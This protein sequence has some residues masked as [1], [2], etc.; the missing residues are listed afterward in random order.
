MSSSSEYGCSS[1]PGDLRPHLLRYV[2]Q[3]R[4]VEELLAASERDREG[5]VEQYSKAEEDGE[6]RGKGNKNE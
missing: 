2:Q 6:G 5:L 1:G 3:V 4:R